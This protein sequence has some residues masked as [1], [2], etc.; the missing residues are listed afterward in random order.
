MTLRFFPNSKGSLIHP[1]SKR[2]QLGTQLPRKRLSPT[3]SNLKSC[4]GR[5][6]L[7]SEVQPWPKHASK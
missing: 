6:Q 4:K 3:G 1:S 7:Y 2:S 5:K